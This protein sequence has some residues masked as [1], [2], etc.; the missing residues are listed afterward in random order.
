MNPQKPLTRL[1]MINCTGNGIN[2]WFKICSQLYY[3]KLKYWDQLVDIKSKGFPGM[4]KIIG[5]SQG[6]ILS[7]LLFFSLLILLF[8][9]R[10]SKH[11]TCFN[12][13]KRNGVWCWSASTISK[14]SRLTNGRPTIGSNTLSTRHDQGCNGYSTRQSLV[15]EHLGYASQHWAVFTRHTAFFCFLS[16]IL[17]GKKIKRVL[18]FFTKIKPRREPK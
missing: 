3:S 11:Y 6:A 17:S 14:T 15:S 5:V 9:H 7:T 4:E 8:L 12:V 1:C 16:T 18:A 2:M 10:L 13:R